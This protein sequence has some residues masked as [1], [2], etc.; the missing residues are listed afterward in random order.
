MAAGWLDTVWRD[1]QTEGGGNVTRQKLQ[2]LVGESVLVHCTSLSAFL[3]LPK[4]A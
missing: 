1:R 4:F 2:N 3:H